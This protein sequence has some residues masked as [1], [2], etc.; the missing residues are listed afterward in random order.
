MINP[1]AEIMKD[2]VYKFKVGDRVIVTVYSKNV[3][4][5]PDTAGNNYS[6]LSEIVELNYDNFDEVLYGVKADVKSRPPS[7]S[8]E[9]GGVQYAYELDYDKEYY[10]EIKLNDILEDDI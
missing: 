4:G 10:R 2:L 9:V 5:L 7:R 6:F 3:F 8:G 1:L